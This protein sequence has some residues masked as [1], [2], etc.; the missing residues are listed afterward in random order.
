MAKEPGPLTR[1]SKAVRERRL[2]ATTLVTESL[3][4]LEAAQPSLNVAAE[5]S[6]DEALETASRVDR[7][8][9]RVGPLLG[10][11]TLIKDLEDW[12]GHPTRKGSVALRDAPAAL[13]NGTVPGRL[14]SA[15]AIPVGKSTL[16]EFAIE[17]YTANL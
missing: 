1:L 7:S 3:R 8:E 12:R 5:L 17:G 15:G 4:R 6:F 11:P 9:E 10:A 16:P 13:A 14:V 2:S